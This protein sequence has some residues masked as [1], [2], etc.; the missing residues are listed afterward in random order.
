MQRPLTRF[1]KRVAWRR[2]IVTA[3]PSRPKPHETWRLDMSPRSKL[4]LTAALSLIVLCVSGC[5]HR[6]AELITAAC[7]QPPLL[8]AALRAESPLL[9]LNWDEL[10]LKQFPQ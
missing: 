1:E 4:L 9:T 10:I 2:S 6:R 8:P 7:P 5:G 3:K